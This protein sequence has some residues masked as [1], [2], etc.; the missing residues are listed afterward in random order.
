V[1][2]R[3]KIVPKPPPHKNIKDKEE[4]LNTNQKTI[5]T[6]NERWDVPVSLFYHFFPAISC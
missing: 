6:N 2:V 5:T 3:G 1:K 4:A